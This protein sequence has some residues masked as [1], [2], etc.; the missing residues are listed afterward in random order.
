[1]QP[2]VR[3]HG[4]CAVHA[5]DVQSPDRIE[6][7]SCLNPGFQGNLSENSADADAVEYLTGHAGRG[8]CR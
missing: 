6:G 4:M 2:Q 3:I 1:M 8:A 5:G 7:L